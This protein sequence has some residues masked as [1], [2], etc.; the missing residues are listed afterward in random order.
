M[1]IGAF[2]GIGGGVS[3]DGL[4]LMELAACHMWHC[5]GDLS[6]ACC[7]TME[8]VLGR[9]YDID[10]TLVAD[11]DL[12]SGP[13]LHGDFTRYLHWVGTCELRKSGIPAMYQAPPERIRIGWCPN[14]QW[15]TCVRSTLHI[16]LVMNRWEHAP[17]ALSGQLSTG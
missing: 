9:A 12:L 5:G 8:T 1:Y 14:E 15:A 7:Q 3:T 17:E 13:A 16:Q 6:G 11:L 4:S 2:E 10:L